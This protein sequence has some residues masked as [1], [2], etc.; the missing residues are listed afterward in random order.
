MKLTSAFIALAALAGVGVNAQ[1]NQPRC[2]RVSVRKEI[3]NLS[4]S[5]WQT[6]KSTIT[7]M[8]NSGWM[9]WFGYLHAANFDTIHNCEMFFPF[10]RRFVQDFE[11]V[12]SRFNPNFVMPYWDE[13]RD[14]ANPAGSAV[15]A[16]NYLGGNGQG[17]DSCISNGV[18]SGWTM[19][20]PNNHC[21]QRQ[22]NNGNRINAWYSPEYIQSVLSR[23]NG[24]A[25]LRPGIEF[26]LHG[27]VHLAVGGDMVQMS[28]PN[29]FV[30]WL[31]HTNIDRLW[32][33]WQQSRNHL[34]AID[35]VDSNNNPLSLNSNIVAY[36]EPIRT[37]MQLGYGNMCYS[38]DN[39][40]SVS[41]RDVIRKRNAVPPPMPSLPPVR[42]C[43]PRPNPTDIDTSVPTTPVTYNGPVYQGVYVA[44]TSRP[45][46]PPLVQGVFENVNDLAVCSDH[47]VDNKIVEQLPEDVLSKWFPTY[48][49]N[50]STTTPGSNNY[51]T[52]SASEAEDV[53]ST[54]SAGGH[55]TKSHQSR[56]HEPKSRYQSKSRHHSA[57][58]GYSDIDN[59]FSSNHGLPT[60]VPSEEVHK[61]YLIAKE[62]V[63]D[64]NNAGYQ[65]PFG[66]VYQ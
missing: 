22:F 2:S 32:N 57:E 58:H 1:Q 33:V 35:G 27:A 7:S 23:A 55:K 66:K 15:F 56:S 17:R 54:A 40:S 65:S 30:F 38:Y 6:V 34:W 21:L 9:A 26:S 13:L 36:N 39:G 18:Q 64:L 4:Q 37:V 10:H 46:V 60:H 19:T 12:G 20:Y 28:S 8:Q 61:H 42:K 44:D 59:E 5:E 63:H 14:Y 53:Y 43:I 31:H 41:K 24:M 62:F 45:A 11:Y 3:R 48:T 16:S 29:D 52:A 49:A 25:D 50:N 51:S 47:Y